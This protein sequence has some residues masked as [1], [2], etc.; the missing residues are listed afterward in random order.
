MAFC[1]LWMFISVSI[2]FYWYIL[3]YNQVNKWI[4]AVFYS[5]AFYFNCTRVRE[6][7]LRYFHERWIKIV[8]NLSGQVYITLHLFFFYIF[9]VVYLWMP[10]TWPNDPSYLSCIIGCRSKYKIEQFLEVKSSNNKNFKNGRKRKQALS[11]YLHWRASFH[12]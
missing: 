12:I 4:S 5:L 6:Y 10:N 2:L 1:I 8:S 9:I 11:S 7:V 3:F